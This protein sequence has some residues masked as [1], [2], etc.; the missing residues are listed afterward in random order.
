M[1]TAP[2]VQVLSTSFDAQGV[3]IVT[4]NKSLTNPRPGVV[5]NPVNF[6]TGVPVYF[7]P[8]GGNQV[9]G[10]FSQRWYS[11]TASVTAPQ[12]FTAHSVDSLPSWVVLNATTGNLSPV[13]G[14]GGSFNPPMTAAYDTRVLTGACSRSTSYVY[15]L[16]TVVKSSV[17]SAVVQHFGINNVGVAA[18]L[19]E[20]TIPTITIG[21]HQVL[22]NQGVQYNTPFLIFA[23]TDTNGKVFL[24]RNNWG[25]IGQRSGTPKILM[26]QAMAGN[27]WEY[28]TAKGWSSDPTAA[29]ALTTP[30]G[31][32][33]SKGPCSF[34]EYR[35][36]IWMSTVQIS[37]SEVTSVIYVS[38]GLYDPWSPAGAPISLGTTS[39]WLG[40]TAYLQ[41]TLQANPTNSI[42]TSPANVSAFP[43][44]TAVKSVVG[45]ETS[46]VLTW[47][48]WPIP[49]MA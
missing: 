44:I 25:K 18:L 8:L 15:L 28:Q 49:R 47:N 7:H 3:S 13:G 36:R 29:V 9:L 34:G 10:L 43:Y 24:A 32:L 1:S 20:E 4:A 2:S 22:F 37:G 16:N 42:V 35:D 41:Q 17:T 21:G 31:T 19:A 26:G 38:K 6:A 48:L 23:G 33:I 27:L 40:G 39:T 46:I 14:L 30:T 45:D 12:A 5:Y 11:A